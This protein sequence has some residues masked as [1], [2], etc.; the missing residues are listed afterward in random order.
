MTP[1]RF[2][3]P[4]SHRSQHMRELSL[5]QQRALQSMQGKRP[6]TPESFGIRLSTMLSLERRGLVTTQL[7]I[8]DDAGDDPGHDCGLVPP[9]YSLSAAG[10][11]ALER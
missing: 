6:G 4:V 9:S 11:K 3:Q 5:E 7:G 10:R 8:F 2:S 1:R